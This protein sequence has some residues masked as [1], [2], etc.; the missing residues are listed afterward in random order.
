MQNKKN[1]D[2]YVTIL[3]E[4]VTEDCTL[5]YG[6]KVFLPLASQDII[7]LLRKVYDENKAALEIT[8]EA[9]EYLLNNARRKPITS[10][11]PCVALPPCNTY[12]VQYFIPRQ[13]AEK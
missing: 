11:F 10:R 5:G 1:D 12:S 3:H 9:V 2:L 8:S 13:H 7:R 6:A 4:I